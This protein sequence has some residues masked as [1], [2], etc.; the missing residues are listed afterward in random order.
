MHNVTVFY[1]LLPSAALWAMRF[2]DQIML[3]LYRFKDVNKFLVDQWLN[4]LL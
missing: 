1:G 3:Q 4:S 2:K